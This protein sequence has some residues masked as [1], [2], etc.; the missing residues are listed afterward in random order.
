MLRSEWSDYTPCHGLT[1]MAEA[2][3]DGERMLQ[4]S[5]SERIG[6]A[7]EVAAAG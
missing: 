3:I 4:R 7:V 1:G 6:L 2:L 5:A